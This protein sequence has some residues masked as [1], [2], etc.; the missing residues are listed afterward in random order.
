MVT[1]NTSNPYID[2]LELNNVAVRRPDFSF[3]EGIS[4]DFK[5]PFPEKSD[6]ITETD[7]ELDGKKLD[8]YID[9]FTQISLKKDKSHEEEEEDRRRRRRKALRQIGRTA[10]VEPIRPEDFS[11]EELK[12]FFS[13]LDRLWKRLSEAVE[14]VFDD[15]ANWNK[16]FKKEK[17]TPPKPSP[18]KPLIKREEFNLK[19]SPHM[20]KSN[21]NK[22]WV[23]TFGPAQINNKVAEILY[24][25]QNATISKDA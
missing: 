2:E 18:I 4:E 3:S 25:Y 12:Q 23:L 24:K 16:W 20:W 8:P 10:R 15:F 5:I 11:D 19:R 22:P 1:L 6:F 7:V 14:D 13:F 9:E 17:R 21:P